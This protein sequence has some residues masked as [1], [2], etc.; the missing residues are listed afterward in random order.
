[1]FHCRVQNRQFEGHMKITYL[2]RRVGARWAPIIGLNLIVPMGFEVTLLEKGQHINWN[3]ISKYPLSASDV[4]FFIMYFVVI[5]I[6][7]A[8]YI[9]SVFAYRVGYDEDAVYARPFPSSGPYMRMPWDEI[10]RVDLFSSAQLS[11]AVYGREDPPNEAPQIA[12][13]RLY[14]KHGD[15][16]EIFLINSKQ[17]HGRQL[18]ELV[19]MIHDRCPNAFSDDMQRYL[20]SEKLYPP[21]AR[22][23]KG[24]RPVYKW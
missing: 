14:R 11:K 7:P 22:A 2:S 6:I 24:S 8:L 12:D 23:E 17:L 20:D 19:Q 10:E 16:K 18:K 13:I 9:Y 4:L 3:L 21:Y 1:M 15:E 5:N